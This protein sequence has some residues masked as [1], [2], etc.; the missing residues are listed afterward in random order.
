MLG[1]VVVGLFFA[2]LFYLY[3]NRQTLISELPEPEAPPKV[4]E[5]PETKSRLEGREKPRFDFYTILP[6]MEVVIPESEIN[7]E[8]KRMAEAI[9]KRESGEFLLQAGSFRRM[10]QADSLKARL[11]LLGYEAGIETVTIQDG[12]VWHR[13]RVGPFDRLSK[14]T[15][16]QAKL[17]VNDLHTIVVKLK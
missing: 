1:G 17:R 13:V 10:E 5:A 7:A 4:V 11:A 6:E 12:E 16:A 15:A 8:R 9:E 3:E 14:V 2:G